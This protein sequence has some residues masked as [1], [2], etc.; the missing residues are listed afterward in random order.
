MRLE[1]KS[2]GRICQCN[3]IK[4]RIPIF[5]GNPIKQREQTC[6]DYCHH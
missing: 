2:F 3:P 6:Y 4:Q 1:A 5:N